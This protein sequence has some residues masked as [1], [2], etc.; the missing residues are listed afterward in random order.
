MKAATI[1]ALAVAALFLAACEEDLAPRAGE[2][3]EY[4]GRFGAH[5]SGDGQLDNPSGIAVAP[6]GV[7][8]VADTYNDRVQYFAPGGSYLAS[9]G[10][11]EAA[12]GNSNI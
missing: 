11:R 3:P 10:R 1:C 7:I 4:L 12:T 8:Y 6:N 2:P 9:G 5:G